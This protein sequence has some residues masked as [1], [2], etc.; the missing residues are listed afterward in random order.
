MDLCDYNKVTLD[1]CTHCNSYWL[2]TGEM[3]ML[4]RLRED[5]PGMAFASRES[6]FMCPRCDIPMREYQFTNPGSLMIDHCPQCGGMYCESNE[7]ER[8]LTVK[9]S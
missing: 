1:H 8:A 3:A 6:R 5:V 4:T 9:G 7:L 2:D